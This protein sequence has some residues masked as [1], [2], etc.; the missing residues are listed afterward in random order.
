MWASTI[1]RKDF[2]NGQFRVFV[3]YTDGAGS[4]FE[5]AYNLSNAENL[6]NTIRSRIDQLQ[7]V[8]AFADTVTLGAYTPTP[9]PVIAASDYEIALAEVS[10][11]KN[12]VSLGILKETDQEFVDAVAALKAEY[13]KL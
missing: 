10:R 13:S 5:E 4:S 8:E 7:A 1:D 11:V 9:K 12:L 3:K 6:N 2:S